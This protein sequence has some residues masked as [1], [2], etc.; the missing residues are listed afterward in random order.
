MADELPDLGLPHGWTCW[1]ELKQNAEGAFMGK[2]EL[3]Q[4]SA[5]RCVFVI[6][7][8][9]TREAALARLKLRAD[10]FIEEWEIRTARE[11]GA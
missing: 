9:P 8:Q 7:Q 1:P 5:S 6:A 11:R 3:R 2:A 10:H 4:G